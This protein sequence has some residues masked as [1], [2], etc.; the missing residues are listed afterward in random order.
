MVFPDDYV[1]VTCDNHGGT[2]TPDTY[3]VDD[4][5]EAVFGYL[6]S[7]NSNRAHYII[8]TF[9]KVKDRL[10]DGIIPIANDPFG[11]LICFDFRQDS[12]ILQLFSGIM[13]LR[14]A[15]LEIQLVL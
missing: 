14:L 9:E 4:H 6:L 15:V 13:K 5:G 11:N 7:F 2:P 8:K 1:L 12:K 10:L 3:D